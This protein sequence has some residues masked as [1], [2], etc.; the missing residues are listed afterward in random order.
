MLTLLCL[1]KIRLPYPI[2][3]TSRSSSRGPGLGNAV[4]DSE[5]DEHRE[6]EPRK[7]ER[8]LL[9]GWK[10]SLSPEE[11]FA[12]VGARTETLMRRLKNH[13]VTRLTLNPS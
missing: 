1:V 3:S 6:A 12:W 4:A 5:M 10:K 9:T 13:S 8:E 2:I 7:Q 11:C